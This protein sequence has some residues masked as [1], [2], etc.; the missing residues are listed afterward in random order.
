MISLDPIL[1][2]DVGAEMHL[3]STSLSCEH[4]SIDSTGTGGG[5]CEISNAHGAL[6]RFPGRE[7]MRVISTYMRS[8]SQ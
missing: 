6:G 4:G 8:Y 1:N 3:L 5:F 2:P 7:V